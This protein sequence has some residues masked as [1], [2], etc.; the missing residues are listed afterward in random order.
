[1]TTKVTIQNSTLPGQE[2]GK[3]VMVSTPVL[4][5]SGLVRAEAGTLLRAGEQTEVYVYD[6]RTLLVEEVAIEVPHQPV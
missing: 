2:H 1:M 5:G 3:A 6:G 4:A